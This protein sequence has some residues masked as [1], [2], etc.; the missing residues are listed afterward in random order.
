TVFGDVGRFTTKRGLK[1]TQRRTCWQIDASLLKQHHAAFN[2]A[3][4]AAKK[5]EKQ[6][7][8]YYV[9]QCKGYI[10]IVVRGTGEDSQAVRLH[11]LVAW[12]CYGHPP[13]DQH[14]H[15]HQ[16]CHFACENKSC[17]NPKHLRWG[18][19]SENQEER[20]SVEEYEH[21]YKKWWEKN[22]KGRS[23]PPR[24]TAATWMLDHDDWGTAVDGAKAIA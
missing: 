3:L 17:L 12:W 10:T 13:K 14:G 7:S 19:Q 5:A 15:Q 22:E 8:D 11:S 6:F 16:A 21:A 2:K 23:Q 24:W 9:R 20:R 18:T 4:R 1:K